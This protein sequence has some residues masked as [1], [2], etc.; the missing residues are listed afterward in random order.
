M[1]ISKGTQMSKAM[2]GISG[3]CLKDH[4][5]GAARFQPVPVEPAVATAGPGAQLCMAASLGDAAVFEHSCT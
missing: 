3:L 5:C 1:R 4:A 2:I